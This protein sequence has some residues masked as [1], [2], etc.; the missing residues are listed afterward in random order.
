MGWKNWPYWL[1]GG[2]VFTVIELIFLFLQTFLTDFIN[3]FNENY[4]YPFI[5]ASMLGWAT[6]GFDSPNLLAPFGAVI[7][8]V[9]FLSFSFIIGALIGFIVG[10][11]KS[12]KRG[13]KK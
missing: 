5:L 9:Y 10:K 11:I 7:F 8:I 4:N 2:I 6:A 3:Y 1:K 12:S 13:K